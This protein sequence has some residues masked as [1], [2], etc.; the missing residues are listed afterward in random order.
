[1]ALPMR[2]GS[3]APKSRWARISSFQSERG[4]RFSFS[5][6]PASSGTPKSSKRSTTVSRVAERPASVEYGRANVSWSVRLGKR[7]RRHGST[8]KE[9]K[10][11]AAGLSAMDPTVVMSF[12]SAD[13]CTTTSIG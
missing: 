5:S 2:T 8:A 6:L 11:K 12:A 7:L 4:D 9:C 10:L 3:A 13:N 1:M